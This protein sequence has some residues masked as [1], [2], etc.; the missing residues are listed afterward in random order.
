MPSERQNAVFRRHFPIP[1][2]PKQNR[3][4]CYNCTF[5]RTRTPMF[6]D[7][8]QTLSKDRHF[9]QSAFKNPNK[10]GGLSKVEEKY[11][12]SHEI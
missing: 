9:L 12:K 5:Y 8:S 3:S 11:R 4:V 6:P 7:F 1:I 10:Y 2:L